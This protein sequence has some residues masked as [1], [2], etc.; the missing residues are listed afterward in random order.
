MKKV[1]M[2]WFSQGGSTSAVAQ[3]ISGGL[4]AAGCEVVGLEIGKDRVPDLAQ[5]DTVGI[6]S[7]TY[8]FRPPFVVTDFV[9]SLPDL[10][11]KSTF[12]FLLHG[13]QQGAAG[14][15]LRRLLKAKNGRDVGYFNAS[16]PDYFIG[17]LK[18]GYLFSPDSP[19]KQDLEVAEQFGRE[20]PFR[21]GQGQA[22][23][24]PFDPPTG[25][26]YALERALCNRSFTKLVYA[27]SIHADKNCDSCGVCV[28][29]CP[30]HNIRLETGK[31]PS[32]GRDCLLC[33]TCQLKCPQ[34]AVHT[35]YDWSVF[36]PLLDYNVRDAVRAQI[37]FELTTHSHGVTRRI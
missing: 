9:R 23:L 1:L 27:A 30:T 3:R 16:G 5:F 6:G 17:Y 7:P 21:A 36:A 20:L 25:F 8:V 32:W 12:V 11:G 29:A 33:A 18:R 19:T 15:R 26:M 24:E 2:A 37:P 34:D 28:A 22:A 31:M 4:K 13:T 14:N 10:A 35:P